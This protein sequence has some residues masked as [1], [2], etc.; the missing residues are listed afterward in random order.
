[1]KTINVDS[2][3]HLIL[4]WVPYSKSCCTTCVFAVCCVLLCCVSCVAVSYHRFL[5][6]LCVR[7]QYIQD[8]EDV[9]QLKSLVQR[10]LKFTGSQVARR[11]L[12]NWEK[13]KKM[14]V[15]VG[16]AVFVCL[17]VWG[18]RKR[19]KVKWVKGVCTTQKHNSAADFPP[20]VTPLRSSLPYSSLLH[21]TTAGVPPRVPPCHGRGR[22][23]QEG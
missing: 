19:G 9:R 20:L 8:Y 7:T 1:M 5:V 18:Q 15:K 10:H 12:L 3:P 17:C 4:V 23:H 22:L 21:L 13:E 6:A 2:F 14:F 16:L 11:I